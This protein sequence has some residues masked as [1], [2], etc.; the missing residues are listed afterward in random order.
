M[1]MT[2]STEHYFEDK[3]QIQN[4]KLQSIAFF[5]KN[6]AISYLS[7][8]KMC[9]RVQLFSPDNCVTSQDIKIFAE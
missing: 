3:K 9:G 4:H 5:T 6:Q 1:I 7:R 2:S 8:E